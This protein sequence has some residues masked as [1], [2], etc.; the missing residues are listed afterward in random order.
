M[1]CS[2]LFV[3]P[4]GSLYEEGDL[5]KNPKLAATLRRIAADPFTYYNGSLAE[6]IIQDLREYGMCCLSQ[7][8]HVFTC[9]HVCFRT[10]S[11]A[12]SKYLT[13]AL[14][15]QIHIVLI[16]IKTELLSRSKQFTERSYHLPLKCPRIH[17]DL[18]QQMPLY[19]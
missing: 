19:N 6:D 17:V 18:G 5:L 1:N 10:F 2:E 14:L 15:A 9:I 3:K 4:N 12:F 11:L 16:V 8:M 7:C 13:E